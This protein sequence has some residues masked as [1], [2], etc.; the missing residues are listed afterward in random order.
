MENFIV[1]GNKAFIFLSLFLIYKNGF[2]K[3]RSN[4]FLKE[5]FLC[6]GLIGYNYLVEYNI[7]NYVWKNIKP[8]IRKYALMKEKEFYELKKLEKDH[9]LHNIYD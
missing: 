2:F 7:N 6:S 3:K 5:I 8:T 4:Y 9:K 1:F